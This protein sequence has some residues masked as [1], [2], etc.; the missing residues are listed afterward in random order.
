M[1]I[2]KWSC[3]KEWNKKSMRL[4][5]KFKPALMSF[6]WNMFLNWKFY[7]CVAYFAMLQLLSSRHVRPLRWKRIF[8]VYARSQCK[9][10]HLRSER[11][12]ERVNAHPTS[13]GG[14]CIRSPRVR[15]A[16]CKHARTLCCTCA[17]FAFHLTPLRSGAQCGWVNA[18]PHCNQLF[19]QS[20]NN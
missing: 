10:N 9:G 14:N 15:G 2:Q 12:V 4:Q 13:V 5:N 7:I 8:D 18:F 19:I 17:Y 1:K 6:D 3:C 20:S 11:A 16:R